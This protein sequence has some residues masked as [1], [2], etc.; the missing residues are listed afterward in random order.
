MNPNGGTTVIRVRDY[1]RRNPAEFHGSKVDENSQEY[2][3]ELYKIV[4]IMKVSP[5]EKEEFIT[6]QL[7]DVA[8]V[9]FKQWK[10][11]RAIDGGPLDW[12]K[13]K[14]I[15]VDLFLSS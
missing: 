15:F 3:D 1:S 14:G 13:F 7:K 11:E 6:Y 4:E 5:M 8:Q 9:W 12:E 2:I 10:E